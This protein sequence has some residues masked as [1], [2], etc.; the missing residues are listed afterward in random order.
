MSTPH[1]RLLVHGHAT[2][3]GEATLDE[4]VGHAEH[5]LLFFAGD[6]RRYPE[7]NDLAVILPELARDFREQFQVGLVAEADEKVLAQR[8]GINYYPAL[9]MLGGDADAYIGAISKLQD[10]ATYC[11]EIHELLQA[12]PRRAPSFAIPVVNE[13]KSSACN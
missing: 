13:S 9:V 4:F 5:S 3:V 11:A 12:E 8:Y 10:W 7:S 2:L 6:V 1:E